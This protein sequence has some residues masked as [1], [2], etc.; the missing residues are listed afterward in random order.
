MSYLCNDLVVIC[1]FVICTASALRWPFR[2]T[3]FLSTQSRQSRISSFLTWAAVAAALFSI[4][5][6]H[7]MD[8]KCYLKAQF[9]WN[10]AREEEILWTVLDFYCFFLIF[11]NDTWFYSVSNK[12]YVYSSAVPLPSLHVLTRLDVT[13]IIC[14]SVWTFLI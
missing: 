2:I 7:I 12:L 3:P 14:V 8:N 5:Q 13:L 11:G 10:V 6:S 9:L 1:N 4:I